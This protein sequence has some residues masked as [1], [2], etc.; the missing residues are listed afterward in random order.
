MPTAQGAALRTALFANARINARTKQPFETS[1]FFSIRGGLAISSRQSNGEF[2][3]LLRVALDLD[4]ATVLL[5][6][7]VV[8]D[9]QPK[10]GPLAGRLGREERLEQLVLDVG[11]DANAVV[12]NPHLDHVAEI[13]RRHG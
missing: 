12:A 8:A 7:D 1:G 9:R 10:A 2:G 13:A 3:E 5:S 6:H 11:R 4:R